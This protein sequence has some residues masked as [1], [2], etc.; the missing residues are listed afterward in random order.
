MDNIYI[1]IVRLPAGINESV[2]PCLDGYTIYI[3]ET[4]SQE[5]K[6]RSYNHAMDHIR[7]GDCFDDLL[8][9]SQKEF[10]AHG[11]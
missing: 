1:Y 7:Y 9:V 8:S 11:L 2:E 5:A 10:R 4:L 6:L 3:E